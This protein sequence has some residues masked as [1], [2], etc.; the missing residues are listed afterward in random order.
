[1]FII[2]AFWF[3]TRGAGRWVQPIHNWTPY[4]C[5]DCHAVQGGPQFVLWCICL[6][7]DICASL[8][9][10]MA[11]FV[12]WYSCWRNNQTL[13][14]RRWIAPSK[15][16]RSFTQRKYNYLMQH[17]FFENKFCLQMERVFGKVGSYWAAHVFR[18]F[19]KLIGILWIFNTFDKVMTYILS[20]N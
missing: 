14:V 3:S 17:N 5:A 4:L 12:L 20:T 7:F 6:W 18:C 1:M 15:N 16:S 11:C 19:L 2:A 10:F 9:I 13:W 8:R